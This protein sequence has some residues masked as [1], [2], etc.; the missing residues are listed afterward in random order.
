MNS[1]QDH[2]DSLE[3]LVSGVL[4]EQP[5][6]RAPRSLQSRVL[7]EIERRVALPWWRKS[8]VHWPIAVRGLFLV[9]S[10]G[11]VKLA[12]LFADWCWS[13]LRSPPVEN[14]VQ[15]SFKEAQQAMNALSLLGDV[16]ALFIRS[17]PPLWLYAALCSIGALYV[18]LFGLSATAYRTL[19]ASR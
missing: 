15:P 4:R 6:R 9:A 10:I 13:A 1:N 3:R 12:L 8:F 19:Y 2:R 11:F 7:T 17:L 14:V 5:L 18:A 16:Y